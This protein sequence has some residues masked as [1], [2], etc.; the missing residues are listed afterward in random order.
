MAARTF[1]AAYPGRCEACG[2]GFG[3]GEQVTYTD[4]DQLVHEGCVD[5]TPPAGK[6]ET[7]CPRCFLTACDCGAE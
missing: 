1:A 2:L 6:P 5:V 3:G 4:Q 7:V